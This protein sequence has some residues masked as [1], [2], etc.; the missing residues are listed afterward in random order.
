MLQIVIDGLVSDPQRRRCGKWFPAPQVASKA[1]MCA[2]G[3]LDAN[4]L[5]TSEAISGWPEVDLDA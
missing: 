1:R 2:A 3:D 4:P 5:A